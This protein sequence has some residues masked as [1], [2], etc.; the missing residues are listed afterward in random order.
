MTVDTVETPL[1]G[2]QRGHDHDSTGTRLL[3]NM[4]SVDS[5]YDEPRYT[6]GQFAAEGPDDGGGATPTRRHGS[7]RSGTPTT[8]GAG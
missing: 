6:G 7:T 4:R 2:S 8:P 5:A 3:P 1:V